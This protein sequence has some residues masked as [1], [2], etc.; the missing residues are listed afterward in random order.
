MGKISYSDQFGSLLNTMSL[1]DND[2]TPVSVT[3]MMEA[4]ECYEMKV[5]ET[6]GLSN[7]CQKIAGQLLGHGKRFVD[8]ENN[9]IEQHT[10]IKDHPL[11][12]RHNQLAIYIVVR[13]ST[14]VPYM[15]LNSKE[16]ERLIPLYFNNNKHEY[17]FDA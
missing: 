4:A 2:T 16:E 6:N 7:T 5:T 3:N 13:L 15:L 9:S 17:L 10:D 8:S 1:K 12:R 11:N 14:G